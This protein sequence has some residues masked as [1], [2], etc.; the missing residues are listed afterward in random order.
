MVERS[1]ATRLDGTYGSL[2]H[3][4]RRAL[5]DRLR[6]DDLRV[7]EAASSFDISLAAV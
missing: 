1:R 2:A 6:A 5:L 7:T 3:P 4:V